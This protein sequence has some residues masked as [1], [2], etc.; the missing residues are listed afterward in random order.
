M[1]GEKALGG[2]GRTDKGQN[3]MMGGNLGTRSLISL[4]AAP[5]NLG[6]LLL[7]PSF[8]GFSYTVNNE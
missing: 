6:F 2:I 7:A 1:S 8:Q 4:K 3:I 5:R